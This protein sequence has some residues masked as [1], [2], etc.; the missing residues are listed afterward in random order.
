M[1]KRKSSLSG[2]ALVRLKQ[3]TSLSD[4]E[5]SQILDKRLTVLVEKVPGLTKEY[6]LFYSEKDDCFFVA[7]R[8]MTLGVTIS[9]WLLGHCAQLLR[10][11][12]PEEC[13]MAKKIYFEDKNKPKPKKEKQQRKLL[14]FNFP[15]P[16]FVFPECTPDYDGPLPTFAI[17]LHLVGENGQNKVKD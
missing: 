9:I 7:V 11:I 1:N 17:T 14:P 10:P 13:E 16:T 6:H 8:D 4:A 5:I 12:T 2:H 3:R 15:E